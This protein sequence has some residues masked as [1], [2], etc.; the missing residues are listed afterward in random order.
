MNSHTVV[1]FPAQFALETAHSTN[2]Q[3]TQMPL[4]RRVSSYSNYGVI[5]SN[6][7]PG[8]ALRLVITHSRLECFWFLDTQ[9][10]YVINTSHTHRH[11]QE[12]GMGKGQNFSTMFSPLEQNK[13]ILVNNHLYNT[14]NKSR[15]SEDPHICCYL[16]DTHP[17]MWTVCMCVS[18]GL[19]GNIQYHFTTRFHN[20]ALPV[21]QNKPSLCKSSA[22][23][24]VV[25]GWWT[26]T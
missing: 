21:N 24:G 19:S 20:F 14:A 13:R 1:T 5:K 26:S 12:Q 17:P 15:K 25:W 7:S 4:K 3:T 9:G 16:Q 23:S 22:A 6:L 8:V 10:F 2:T 11:V 18:C